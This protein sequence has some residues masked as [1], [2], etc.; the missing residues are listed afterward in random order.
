MQGVGEGEQVLREYK[1]VLRWV[2][3]SQQE[4]AMCK[5]GCEVRGRNLLDQLVLV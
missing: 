3:L 5:E 2:C 1:R 4:H